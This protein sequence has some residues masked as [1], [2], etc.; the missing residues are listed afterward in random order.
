MEIKDRDEIFDIICRLSEQVLDPVVIPRLQ[1]LKNRSSEDIKDE[2]LGIIDDIVFCA[3][4]SDFIISVLHKVWISSG[5]KEEE[6]TN[7]NTSPTPENKAK[8]KWKT[9]G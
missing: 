8:Y 4:S 6:L 2:L 1:A 7:R 3:W 9:R 5:G